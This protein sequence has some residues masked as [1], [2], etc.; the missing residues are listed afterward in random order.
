MTNKDLIIFGNG[1]LASVVRFYCENVGIKVAGYSVDRDFLLDKTFE[2]LPNIGFDEIEERLN[3]SNHFLF[4]AIGSSDMLGDIREQKMREGENKGYELFSHIFKDDK[5]TS[6]ISI[7]K[8][9]FIMPGC[10][11]DPFVKFGDGVIAWNGSCICHHTKIGDYTFIAPGVA[12]CG[13]VTVGSHCFIGSNATVRDNVNLTDRTLIGAG[14]II[15]HDTEK[16]STYM[17]ARSVKID[18]F[19][20]DLK[21]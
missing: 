18:N 15:T 19:K 12:I 1:G 14:A 21:M 4:I 6:S 17:P 16:N 7:G 10:H 8:N 3:P 13:R 20:G 5:L 2:G 9:T 11:V